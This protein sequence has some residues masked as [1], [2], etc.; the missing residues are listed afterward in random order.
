MI[1][2]TDLQQIFKELAE[3]CGEPIY[4]SIGV[5]EDGN[6]VAVPVFQIN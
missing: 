6:E 5:D 3:C 1:Y 2:I 4:Q